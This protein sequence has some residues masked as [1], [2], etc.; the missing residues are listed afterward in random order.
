MADQKYT[1]KCSTAW[2][3]VATIASHSNHISSQPGRLVPGR[4]PI[5]DHGSHGE[6]RAIQRHHPRRGLSY[7]SGATPV[8]S[9]EGNIGNEQIKSQ[10]VKARDI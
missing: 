6:E 8:F 2:L 5:Y 10:A 1:D 4:S 3:P 9:G 7:G